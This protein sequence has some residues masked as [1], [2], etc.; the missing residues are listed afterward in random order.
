MQEVDIAPAESSQDAEW[1]PV[2]FAFT[3]RGGEYFRIWIV[4]LF[5][6]IVTLGIY[7]AWAKVRR[8][9]YFHRN[10]SVAGSSFD[11]HARPQ[12]ILRGRVVA[13]AA[14]VLIQLSALVH[15]VLNI[16]ALAVLMVAMP[17]IVVRALRFRLHHTSHRG[18]RF[19][20]HG[21]TEESYRVFLGIGIVVAATLGLAFPFF[22]QRQTRFFVGKSAFG[23][24]RFG[25][26]APVSA[27]YTA[28]GLAAVLVVA[29]AVSGTMLASTAEAAL[30]ARSG[31][32]GF[33]PVFSIAAIFLG[34]A[35][36]GPLLQAR[37]HNATWNHALLG[38]HRFHS[39]QR[40]VSLLWLR[41]SNTLATIATLG[42][43]RPFAVVRNARYRAEHMA[44]IPAGSLDEFV[45]DVAAAP[46]AAGEEVA[47]IFDF[48]FGL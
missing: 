27:Y 22:V 36:V 35:M 20:F 32:H 19:R 9:R 41:L 26:G 21:K 8:E 48:G 7:S 13:V 45:A 42:L 6:S 33:A 24:S 30:L 10:T 18:I 3:G 25:F 31:Y 46:S 5:L 44:L 34:F 23:Q 11:Y 17:W 37:L 47:E 28:F 14:F 4:N 39:E 43:F 16:A 15:P 12:A 29:V 2:P 38:S 1:A 40:F